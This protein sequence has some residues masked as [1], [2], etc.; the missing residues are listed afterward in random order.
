[1]ARHLA[2]DFAKAGWVNF[3]PL[4]GSVVD[5]T[6]SFLYLNTV[7]KKSKRFYRELLFRQNPALTAPEE[8]EPAEVKLV[9][10]FVTFPH[11]EGFEVKAYLARP[12]NPANENGGALVVL[13][14]EDGIG[15]Q[16]YSAARKLA[17]QGYVALA[18][19]LFARKPGD[20]SKQELNRDVAAAVRYLR[21]NSP[22]NSQIGLLGFGWGGDAVLHYIGKAAAGVAFYPRLAHPVI[23]A[24]LQSPLLIQYGKE[25]AR[26]S[27]GA[28]QNLLDATRAAKKVGEVTVYEGATTRFD[29]VDSPH[30]KP[31]IAEI[32]WEET[33]TWFDKYLENSR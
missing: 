23:V 1:L 22:E 2:L 11:P 26:V 17:R 4:L 8:V 31:A 3:I 7:G 10:R 14:D 6:Y 18:P 20:L 29:D 19:N 15:E 28:V 25:N 33:L 16:V 27:D 13:H 21:E 12:D 5:G 32:A 24:D 30:Y 9:S